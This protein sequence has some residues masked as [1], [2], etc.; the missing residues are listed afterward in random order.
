MAIT[1]LTTPGKQFSSS[2]TVTND[3]L[4]LLGQP[5]FVITGTVATSDL[6]D[7]SVSAAK[8]KQDAFAYAAGAFSGGVYSVN[9]TPDMAAGYTVGAIVR[10]KADT[11]NTGATDINVDARGAADLVKFTYNPAGTNLTVELDAGDIQKDQVVECICY[12]AGG[13]PRFLMLSTVARRL[14]EYATASGTNTYTASL[15]PPI[16]A[17]SQLRGKVLRILFSNANTSTAPTLNIDGIGAVNIKK[18]KN[19]ALN[20]GDI[21]ASHEVDL[22]YDGTSFVV[23]S[24]LAN[25]IDQSAASWQQL[26][27]ANNLALPTQKVDVSATSVT[28][29]DSDGGTIT[30]KPVVVTVDIAASGAN[31]LDSGASAAN[32]YYIWLISNGTTTAGLLSLQAIA[33]TMPSGY[34]YKIRVGVVRNT[35][36]GNNLETFIQRDKTVAIVAA[37]VFTGKGNSAYATLGGAELT[38]FQAK[39]PPIA[40]YVRGVAGATA[41]QNIVFQLG[42]DATQLGVCMV[43]VNASAITLNG[44]NSANHWEIPLTSNT[45]FYGTSV[46]GGTPAQ[47]QITGYTITG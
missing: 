8:V 30:A 10:F 25:R 32:F 41:N 2:E 26:T 9:L 46:S 34:T 39:V 29:V 12:Q 42:P 40:A 13:S 15:T 6:A 47:L 3:K 37:T 24:L 11:T 20:V 14:V 18:H 1:V 7:D 44:Y 36:A 23:Q 43:G 28:M 19:V 21:A 16:T 5:T 4:N 22:A 17:L 38:A 35:A 45:M 27:I 33:P 31:G